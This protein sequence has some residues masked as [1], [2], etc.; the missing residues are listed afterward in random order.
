MRLLVQRTLAADVK[1]NNEIVGKIGKGALVFVGLT[2]TDT[3]KESTWLAKKLLSL[4]FFEDGEGKINHSLEEEK[5]EILVV[6]QFTLYADCQAGRR[7]SFTKAAAPL[8][9][10]PLYEH[11]IEEL[12][13]SG[14]TIQTGIFGADMKVALINDG[15]VTLLLEREA[16]LIN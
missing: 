14:L 12:K 15:P 6:S 4:R 11:F 1:V 3:E 16:A 5:A 2:H 10:I 9:A 8:V 7:P 13:K